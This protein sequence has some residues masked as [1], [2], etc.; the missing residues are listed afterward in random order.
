MHKGIDIANNTGTAIHAA[1]DGV[2]TYSG[3]SSGYG[4]LV[5]MS[6]LMVSR[7]GTPDSRLLVKRDRWFLGVHVFL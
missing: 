6:T 5:E 4:Y 3:W 2:I 7:R 1:R